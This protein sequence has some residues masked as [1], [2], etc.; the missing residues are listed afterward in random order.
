MFQ[1]G[2]DDAAVHRV[3]VVLA[4][5]EREVLR[6]DLDARLVE[7][8]TPLIVELHDAE[9]SPRLSFGEGEQLREKRCRSVFVVHED[10]GVVQ[11]N[12]Y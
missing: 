6:L 9:R 10:D 8:D 7:Q 5:E 3:E 12:G 2:F 1:F 4:N 11:G